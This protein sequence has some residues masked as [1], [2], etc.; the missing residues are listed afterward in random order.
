MYIVGY[1]HP[2]CLPIATTWEIVLP[3]NFLTK[4]RKE[5]YQKKSVRKVLLLFPISSREKKKKNM[6]IKVLEFF[7]KVLQLFESLPGFTT[8]SGKKTELKIDSSKH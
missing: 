4:C 1:P 6:S 7:L 8:F 5:F 3:T 2:L